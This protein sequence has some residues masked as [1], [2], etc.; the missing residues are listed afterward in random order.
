M[1]VVRNISY[2]IFIIVL[3]T[4]YSIIIIY[5]YLF[6]E[7]C[8]FIAL[9]SLKLFLISNYLFSITSIYLLHKA[10][11]LM[12]K[13]LQ[14]G[15]DILKHYVTFYNDY[16]DIIKVLLTSNHPAVFS[17]PHN[18]IKYLHCTSLGNLK[19]YGFIF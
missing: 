17:S 2:T 10:F 13:Y 14:F 5:R 18:S 8:V 16:G 12:F 15:A 9:F 11:L 1:E 6:K 7:T 19:F 3:F 4:V